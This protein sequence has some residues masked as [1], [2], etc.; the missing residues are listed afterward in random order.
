M[1]SKLSL[2]SRF[3]CQLRLINLLWQ[4]FHSGF[5]SGRGPSAETPSQLPSSAKWTFEPL[6]ERHIKTVPRIGSICVQAT[7]KAQTHI[8]DRNDSRNLLCSFP[9]SA[10][11]VLPFSNAFQAPAFHI[12]ACFCQQWNPLLC[13]RSSNIDPSQLLHSPSNNPQEPKSST[14]AHQDASSQKPP[15]PSP[16]SSTSRPWPNT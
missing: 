2:G 1:S 3:I 13:W 9:T 16:V 10:G 5:M 4:G 15:S 6:T 8:E 7:S 11:Y 14:K 12:Y